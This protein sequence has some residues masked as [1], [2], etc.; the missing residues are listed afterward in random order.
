MTTKTNLTDAEKF[1]LIREDIGL[2][3]GM[4]ARDMGVTQSFLSQVEKGLKNVS[5]DLLLK[6]FMHYGYSS[7]WWYKG[8]GP[9]K[10]PVVEDKTTLVR[11][12]KMLTLK[13]QIMEDE[14]DKLKADNQWLMRKLG[15][16]AHAGA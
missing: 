8:K 5:R 13:I 11:D 14:I 16:R 9:M 2:S 7:E 3:Q 4:L 12:I 6:I 10:K 1:R 15:D